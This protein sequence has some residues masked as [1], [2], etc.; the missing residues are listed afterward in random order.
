MCIQQVAT[1]DGELCGA[2]RPDTG[3]LRTKMMDFRV[4]DSSR[5]LSLRGGIP[6]PIGNCLESLSQAILVGIILAGRLGTGL[7]H[8]P[9]LTRFTD[10]NVIC[11]TD[12]HGNWLANI[13]RPP[14]L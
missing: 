7:C 14:L 10:Y 8:Y 11:E 6:R 3:N 12:I 1:F 4:F 9:T 2:A 13:G 5:I